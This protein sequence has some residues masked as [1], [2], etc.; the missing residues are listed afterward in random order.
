MGKKE[1]VAEERIKFKEIK[2]TTSKK[3]RSWAAAGTGG[4]AS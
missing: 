3:T 2:T 4:A 1:S